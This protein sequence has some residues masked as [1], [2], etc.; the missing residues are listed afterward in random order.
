MWDRHCC[1]KVS[2]PFSFFFSLC[3]GLFNF[4]FVV[5]KFGDFA[6]KHA[7]LVSAAVSS[8][9]QCE[10]KQGYVNHFNNWGSEKNSH[11]WQVVSCESSDWDGARCSLSCCSTNSINA[12]RVEVCWRVCLFVCFQK[13]QDVL[14]QASPA[15]VV[16]RSLPALLSGAALRPADWCPEQQNVSLHFIL[17]TLQHF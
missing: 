12:F 1:G 13:L 3:F 9:L 14:L 11:S 5:A 15:A 16:L 4:S 10:V 6:V 7:G 8:H 17:S 2:F